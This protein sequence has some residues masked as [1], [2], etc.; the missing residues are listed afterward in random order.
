MWWVWQEHDGC[1]GCGR[2]MMGVWWVWQEH[3]GCG[4]CSR[5]M[6]GVVGVAGT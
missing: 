2:N 4:G 3:D 5:N 1:R 6:M